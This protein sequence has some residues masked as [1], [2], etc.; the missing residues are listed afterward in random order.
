ML[1][2]I[3]DGLGPEGVA[4][5]GHRG[6]AEDWEAFWASWCDRVQPTVR[7]ATDRGDLWSVGLPMSD[8][9]ETLSEFN[10]FVAAY[11]ADY[12]TREGRLVIDHLRSG[13]THSSGSIRAIAIPWRRRS[14]S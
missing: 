5:G 4:E 12:V 3:D 8:T 13:A 1:H 7:Q 6:R 2:P 14:S 11:D 9:G 10:Q